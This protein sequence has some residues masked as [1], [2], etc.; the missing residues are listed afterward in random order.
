MKILQEKLKN[1]E[2]T[3]DGVLLALR[4]PKC[5]VYEDKVLTFEFVKKANDVLKFFKLKCPISISNKGKCN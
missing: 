2:M 3:P 4:N 5:K 1:T